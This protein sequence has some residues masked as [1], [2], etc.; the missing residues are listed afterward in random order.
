MSSQMPSQQ[1]MAFRLGT[2]IICIIAG[3]WTIFHIVWELRGETADDYWGQALLILFVLALI[4]AFMRYF[5]ERPVLHATEPREQ[6]PEPSISRFFFASTGAAVLWF[7]VRMNVGALWFID[8]WEKV[9]SPRWGTSATA[10][11][12]FV[13][14]ALA[15]T[16]GP[17]PSVQGWYANF[18]ENFVL[19][20]AGL[21]SVLVSWGELAVGLGVLL[22]ALTGIAAGFGVLMNLN[23][24]LAGTVSINPILGTLG[25]FLCFAWRVCGWIGLDRWLLPAL[26]L[27]WKPGEMFRT[28]QGAPAT[29]P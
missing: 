11:K 3:A 9:Q 8:G 21:F 19:P 12:G 23:Y 16:G 25:L 29:S 17:N 27:P 20:N 10:L 5:E 6:F 7:V 13:I 1:N 28:P 24:L 14:T 26:G 15:K 18:L 4:L 2:A 22:G